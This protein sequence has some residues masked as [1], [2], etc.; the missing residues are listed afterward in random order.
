MVTANWVIKYIYPHLHNVPW[1]SDG[2]F[3]TWFGFYRSWHRRLGNFALCLP[4]L[5]LFLT[6]HICAPATHRVHTQTHKH[7]KMKKTPNNTAQDVNMVIQSVSVPGYYNYQNI[8]YS[9]HTGASP[10]SP[11]SFT[12]QLNFF[13]RK[14]KMDA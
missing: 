7:F 9:Q 3:H 8:S 2:F 12:E 4:S 5:C 1:T 13:W 14:G 10:S 6:L 11:L